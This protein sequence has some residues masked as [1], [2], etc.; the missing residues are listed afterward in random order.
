MRCGSYSPRA[1]RIELI[2]KV[3]DQIKRI[4]LK[5]EKIR[6]KIMK[7]TERPHLDKLF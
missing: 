7:A 2:H 5:N 4:D 3:K 1:G 6:I